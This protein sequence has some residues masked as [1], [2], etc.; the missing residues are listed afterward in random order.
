MSSLSMISYVEQTKRKNE[1]NKMRIK[2]QNEQ[3]Y[4]HTV[5]IHKNY[6]QN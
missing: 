1:R 3:K 4:I 2:Q 6:K 5:A